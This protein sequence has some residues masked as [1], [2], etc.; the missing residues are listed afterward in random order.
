[1]TI[2]EIVKSQEYR[3]VVADYRDT[4]LWFAKDVFAPK[5]RLQLEQILL[6]IETNGDMDAFKRAGRIRKWL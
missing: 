3:S 1:M 2:E 6:A 5:D 4:C